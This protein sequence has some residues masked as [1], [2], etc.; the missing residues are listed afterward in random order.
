MAKVP[1]ESVWARGSGGCELLQPPG[2]VLQEQ[3]SG[4]VVPCLPDTL[5]VLRVLV[6]DDNRDAADS[7]SI[8]V[9]LWGDTTQVAY[10]GAAALEM[11]SVYQPHVLLLDLT[12]PKMDGCELARQLRQQTAFADTL[13]IAITGWTDL[14]HRL[15][16]DK[17]G[18]DH[19]LLKPI[20]LSRL[21]MLLR[22][23]RVRLAECVPPIAYRVRQT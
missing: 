16:C 9:N 2:E 1:R 23:E 3:W 13:L 14:S 6:V 22:Q 18:F 12:M 4:D 19:Y 10:D 8:V 5:R 17:A 11:T 15:L 21:E 7:L 20:D